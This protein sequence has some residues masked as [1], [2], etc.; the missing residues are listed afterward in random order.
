MTNNTT[1]KWWRSLLATL[2]AYS[3]CVGVIQVPTSAA[4][5]PVLT[6][7]WVQPPGYGLCRRRQRPRVRDVTWEAGFR[8]VLSV[9][10][11]L[12]PHFLTF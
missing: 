11:L 4:A 6:L 3:A 1:V 9:Q 5:S 12:T 8:P 2:V 10:F 7:T